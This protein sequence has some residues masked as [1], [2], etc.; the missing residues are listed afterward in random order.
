[1]LYT[2]MSAQHK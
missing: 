2:F 1:M